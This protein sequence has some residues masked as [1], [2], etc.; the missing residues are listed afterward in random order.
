MVT[1][2]KGMP[3]EEPQENSDL[4]FEAIKENKNTI[5][6]LING[7]P[8]FLKTTTF[9]VENYNINREAKKALGLTER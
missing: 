3:I 4:F 1:A 7:Y 5:R 8:V 6:N 9:Q 2:Y